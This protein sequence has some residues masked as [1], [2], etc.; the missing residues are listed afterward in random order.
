MCRG[1]EGLGDEGSERLGDIE[2]GRQG[3]CSDEF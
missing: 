2:T 3:K 1:D